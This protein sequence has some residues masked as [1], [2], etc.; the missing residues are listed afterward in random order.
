MK[1]FYTKITSEKFLKTFSTK[2]CSKF[3][4]KN[5]KKKKGGGQG[6][7]P[8]TPEFCKIL[9]FSENWGKYL[10]KILQ[11]FAKFCK[12][13]QNFAKFCKILQN[14]AKFWVN[15]YPNFRKR[16]IFCKIQGSPG[17]TPD[18][19]PFFFLNFSKKIYCRF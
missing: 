6:L 11:Y 14:I 19:H 5:L 13:L 8:V 9:S 15:I 7:T 12:I 10:P 18:P 2:I 17:S 1:I 4:L 16:T 3:F